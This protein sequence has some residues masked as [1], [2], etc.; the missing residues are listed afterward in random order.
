[1]TAFLKSLGYVGQSGLNKDISS[2]MGS[3][4]FHHPEVP[5]HSILAYRDKKTGKQKFMSTPAIDHPKYKDGETQSFDTDFEAVRYGAGHMM[6]KVP[7][8]TAFKSVLRN[9]TELRSF[10]DF[11]TEGDV[12]PFAP[13]KDKADRKKRVDHGTEMMIQAH[14][15]MI[16][17]QGYGPGK[18]DF[19]PNGTI[20]HLDD[21]G[22][23][24]IHSF[25]IKT[26]KIGK[27]VATR[28][29][30]PKDPNQKPI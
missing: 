15:R 29:K 11:M 5:G 14:D 8:K 3:E 22:L 2:R 16:H 19:H 6:E 24:R 27:M 9:D 13:Y 25:D 26:G 30:Q 12:V 10:K 7:L 20:S 4:R 18:V 28:H 23:Q 21:S 1:M 17:P